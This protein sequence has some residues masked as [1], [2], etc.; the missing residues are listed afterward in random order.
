MSARFATKETPPTP[1]IVT[2]C[3]FIKAQFGVKP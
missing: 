3:L 1:L 2:H